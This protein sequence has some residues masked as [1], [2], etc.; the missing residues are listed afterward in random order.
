MHLKYGV[1]RD[2]IDGGKAD[3]LD[4][5]ALEE[6]ILLFEEGTKKYR[7]VLMKVSI[8][9]PPAKAM[10]THKNSGRAYLSYVADCK[11]IIQS[12]DL[13]SGADEDLFGT[14]EVK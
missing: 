4:K 13:E 3:E 11:E 12:I 14:S 2:T 5:P 1:V 10:N 8:L 9:R 7:A 6:I